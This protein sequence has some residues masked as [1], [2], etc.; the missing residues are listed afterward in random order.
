M[1]KNM[2]DIDNDDVELSNDDE[3]TLK[4]HP[5]GY[6]SQIRE[7][8]AI[9]Y[10]LS[11]DWVKLSK[12]NPVPSRIPSPPSFTPHHPNPTDLDS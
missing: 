9:P 11:K 5:S 2:N 8:A 1:E 7:C 10:Q 3:E 6:N 4:S 12:K